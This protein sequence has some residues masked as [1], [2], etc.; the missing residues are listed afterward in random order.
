MKKRLISELR[1]MEFIFVKMEGTPGF[2][3]WN[4]I[5]ITD[6]NG[7]S[8][9]NMKIHGFGLSPSFGRLRIPSFCLIKSS[10]ISSGPPRISKRLRLD[11]QIP[12]LWHS[13]QSVRGPKCGALFEWNTHSPPSLC[14]APV[15]RNFLIFAPLGAPA[16]R[17]FSLHFL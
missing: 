2:F 17:I 15:V 6:S 11:S 4:S 7:F 8:I 12:E 5:K 9:K 1:P 14:G 13:W 3:Y 16:A 10:R